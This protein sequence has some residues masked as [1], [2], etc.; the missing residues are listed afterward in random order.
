MR[1]KSKV[2]LQ[3]KGYADAENRGPGRYAAWKCRYY[4]SAGQ[5]VNRSM[6]EDEANRASLKGIH[7]SVCCLHLESIGI[8]C[9]SGAVC[10]STPRAY[11]DVSEKYAS[12]QLSP[13]VTKVL[14]WSQDTQRPCSRHG[15]SHHTPVRTPLL[16]LTV[17]PVQH[18]RVAAVLRFCYL[19][20]LSQQCLL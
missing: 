5:W 2:Q 7:L 8:R 15:A 9:S 19:R 1:C 16:T 20:R 4:V 11:K 12:F 17:R 10:L 18:P 6:G 13:M 3:T 14:S